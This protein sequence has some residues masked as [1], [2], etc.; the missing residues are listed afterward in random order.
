M[1]VLLQFLK[2]NLVVFLERD[3]FD[4]LSDSLDFLIVNLPTLIF[5][6]SALILLVLFNDS[7]KVLVIK[8]VVQLVGMWW[9]LPV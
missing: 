7:I 2:L 3:V 4:H 6:L 8:V 5:E 9:C 1:K